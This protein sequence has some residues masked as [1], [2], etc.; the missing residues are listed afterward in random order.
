[1]YSKKVGWYLKENIPTDNHGLNL[2]GKYVTEQVQ[3]SQKLSDEGLNIVSLSHWDLLYS[4][5]M[6]LF[7]CNFIMILV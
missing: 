3:S 1:M 6:I 4:V 5:P 7:H 2:I